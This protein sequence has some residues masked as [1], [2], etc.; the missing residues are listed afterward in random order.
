MGYLIDTNV[1]SELRKRDRADGGVVTFYRALPRD[2]VFTSVIVLGEI[3]HGI[4]R[5]RA[6]D[7]A[8]AGA[9]DRWLNWLRTSFRERI[10]MITEEIADRWGHLGLAEPVPAPDALLAAT[11]LVHDLTL[12]TRNIKDVARTG[13]RVLNPF[14]GTFRSK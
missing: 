11:A 5:I 7:G 3:R 8:A 4:E 9:L 2:E 10:L 6:R 14:T 1:L 13:A 12:V